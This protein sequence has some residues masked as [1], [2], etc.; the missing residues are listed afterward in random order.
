ML[1]A[2]FIT[3]NTS[4]NEHILGLI[5]INVTQAIH[6]EVN[7]TSIN[8]AVNTS[9]HVVKLDGIAWVFGGELLVMVRA[10]GR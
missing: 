9:K 6:L 7:D 8:K 2:L 1:T 5:L 3:N 10:A 4:N